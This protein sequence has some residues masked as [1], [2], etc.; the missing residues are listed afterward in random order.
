M[1]I[2]KKIS[3]IALSTGFLISTYSPIMSQAT[4]LGGMIRFQ[5]TQLKNIL[6]LTKG[7]R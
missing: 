4:E 7:L 6:I 3:I 5:I 2:R 1:S